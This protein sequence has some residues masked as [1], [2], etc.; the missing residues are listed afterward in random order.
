[1][2]INI[3]HATQ[4]FIESCDK[5]SV[6]LLREAIAEGADLN[7]RD[8]YGDSPFDD[9]ML[10]IEKPFNDEL[11]GCYTSPYNEEDMLKF[12]S[13]LVAGGFNVG[14]TPRDNSDEVGTFW[15][16]AK[17]G[18]SLKLLEYL[19]SKGLNPNYIMEEGYSAL[20]E[21]ESHIW[22]E[23]AACGY[24]LYASYLYEAAR[25]SVAYG[26]LPTKLIKGEYKPGEKELYQAAINLDI[27][28]FKQ[29]TAEELIK[30]E[31]DRIIINHAKYG[32]PRESYY[33]IDKFQRRIIPVLEEVIDKIGIDRL[34][35]HTLHDCVEHQ[36][37][38]ILEYLLKRGANPY[39]NCFTKHYRH[40]K[41]S[42]KYTLEKEGHYYQPEARNRMNELLKHVSI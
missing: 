15:H 27:E 36:Y 7:Y 8:E 38:T 31:A 6:D 18:G 2:E 40:I 33:E 42:A 16:V 3:S 22:L 19:L 10:Y 25:L 30:T 39:A 34:N 41:S 5:F 26:A 23:D 12:A 4:K 14:H 29:R 35:N 11:N 17:W 37:V 32:S 20:D 24:P 21:L 1:M 9:M 13:M 28:Y